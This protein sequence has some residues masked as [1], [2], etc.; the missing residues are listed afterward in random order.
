MADGAHEPSPALVDQ[1]GRR[2][3]KLRLSLTDRCNLRCAYCMPEHPVWL[4][5]K[6][7]LSFEELQRLAGLF[8]REL[9]ITN[10]RLT[11]GEP[12]LRRDLPELVAGLQGLRA[13]GLER[14]SMTTNATR[15]DALAAPLKQAGL[16]DL[17]ISIDARDPETFR[18]LTRGPIEPVLEGI[19][20]AR[21]AGLAVKLNAVVIRDYNEDEIEPLTAWA[22]EQGLELRFIEFMPLDGQQNWSR[23]R[24]VAEPEILERLARR[25]RIERLPRT[26]ADPATE[27]RLDGVHRLGIITTVSKPFCASCDRVRLTATGELFSCLFAST[28]QGLREALRAGAD[29]TE[30]LAQIRGV[31]WNKERGYAAP[32]GYVERPITMHRLGG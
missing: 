18:R 13:Q 5:R 22:V 32:Q 30:L 1:H 12:T 2:K 19:A 23:E 21:A 29:D 28:G 10:I 11:G 20:A 17:N 15:L 6:D 14:L 24:V 4:P 9:G 3:R 27:Y 31:V 7:L 8:V 16:D 26:S 25:Y